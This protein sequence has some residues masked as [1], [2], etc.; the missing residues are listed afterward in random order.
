M[1]VLKV[2]GIRGL[3][4]KAFA[5][6]EVRPVTPF[7]V[8]PY[9]P[10]TPNDGYRFGGDNPP[11]TPEVIGCW[12]ASDGM[13]DSSP[14]GHDMKFV[15]GARME[16]GMFVTGQDLAYGEVRFDEEYAIP[17]AT[18]DMYVTPS[19]EGLGTYQGVFAKE[20]YCG[21]SDTVRVE[22]RNG[23]WSLLK[24]VNGRDREER[25]GPKA[26]SRRTRIT[27]TFKDGFVRFYV[28]GEEVRHP[29][30]PVKLS[31][32]AEARDNFYKNVYILFGASSIHK[33]FYFRG[34]CESLTFTSKA[35]IPANK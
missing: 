19:A 25:V 2:D 12:K 8:I 35:I 21:V 33:G 28:D 17:E 20:S 6:G 7:G 14:Q 15:N 24:Y 9:V 13:K 4:A 11:P 5:K 18:Y 16:N 30:G 34:A 27:V 10:A 3:G 26:E 29:R 32:S 1:H 23:R 22:I 31:S